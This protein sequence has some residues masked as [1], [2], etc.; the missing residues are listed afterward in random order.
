MSEE[1]EKNKNKVWNK[2][3]KEIQMKRQNSG[4]ERVT[5]II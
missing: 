1:Q 5:I 4:K 2:R 3:V